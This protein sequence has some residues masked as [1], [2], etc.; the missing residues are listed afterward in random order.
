MKKPLTI[1]LTIC[2]LLGISGFSLAEMQ[3]YIEVA[4]GRISNLIRKEIP[5]DV[6]IDRLEVIL[7]RTN[8]Q[9]VRHQNQIARTGLIIEHADELMTREKNEC[10]S[11]LVSMR[12]LRNMQGTSNYPVSGGCHSHSSQNVSTALAYKY[13]S[14]QFKKSSWESCKKLVEQQKVAYENY[15]REYS[16]WIQKRDLLIQKLETLKT[17][18]AAYEAGQLNSESSLHASDLKRASELADE[19]ERNLK[20]EE[21]KSQLEKESGRQTTGIADQDILSEIDQLLEENS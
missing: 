11:L 4:R 6:E 17:R 15:T 1:I 5:L 3:E 10:N 20:V 12:T 14:Y 7:K 13:Q 9:V 8:E 18:L 16:E 19:I 2:C 21:K